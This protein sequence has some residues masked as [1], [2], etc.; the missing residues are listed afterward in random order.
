MC[1]EKFDCGAID[2]LKEAEFAIYD[3][4]D[5]RP[6][7]GFTYAC[8]E[9]VGALL[10]SAPPVPPDGPWTVYSLRNIFR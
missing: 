8:E 6:D 9:H 3:N 2:C 10:G 7:S 4:L 5:R 1:Q